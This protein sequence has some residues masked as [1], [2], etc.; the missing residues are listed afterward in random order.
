M[1]PDTHQSAIIARLYPTRCVADCGCIYYGDKLSSP[2][3]EH[4][5]WDYATEQR[6]KIATE[7]ADACAYPMTAGRGL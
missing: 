1:T 7:F 3:D 5:E 4:E 6:R 2:C